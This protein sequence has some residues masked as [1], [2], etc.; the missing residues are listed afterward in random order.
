MLVVVG[1]FT[2]LEAFLEGATECKYAQRDPDEVGFLKTGKAGLLLPL[3]LMSEIDE[4]RRPVG[5]GAC[6]G[7]A[8]Q[9]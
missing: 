1:W 6:G 8:A 2:L 5:R 9:S 7:A 4:G 3:T